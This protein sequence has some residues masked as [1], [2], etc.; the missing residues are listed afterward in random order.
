M[1]TRR[2]AIA[3]VAFVLI[4]LLFV[5]TQADLIGKAFEDVVDWIISIVKKVPFTAL[6]I[7]RRLH[8]S[9]EF[10]GPFMYSFDFPAKNITIIYE[11]P[12]SDFLISDEKIGAQGEVNVC[13]HK[14]T[15][16]LEL[17]ISEDE[18][19]IDIKGKAVE[20]V[21]NGVPLQ[22]PSRM[23]V[24]TAGIKATLVRIQ[25]AE[26]KK[27]TA[28]GLGGHVLVQGR[29]QTTL[30]EDSVSFIAFLGEVEITPNKIRFD[31]K[32]R[33]AAITGGNFTLTIG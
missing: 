2:R 1:I 9:A 30:D 6:P 16:K 29:S 11:T 19:K 23:S 21:I 14:W 8:I 18:A 7:E 4:S 15:G 22:S 26:I 31:G 17:N 10:D 20:V 32:V 5:V 28:D 3:A 13:M 24:E 25:E 27:F 33:R 12:N